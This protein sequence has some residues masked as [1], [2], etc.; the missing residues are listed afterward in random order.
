MICY[1]KNIS[2]KI[3]LVIILTL[4]VL[5]VNIFSFFNPNANNGVSNDQIRLQ[6]I[7][8]SEDTIW[9]V[10]GSPYVINET[11]VIE[12][13]AKLTIESGVQVLFNESS[14]LIIDGVL[15]ATGTSANPIIFTSNSSTPAKGDWDSIKIRG[16][17]SIISN[18]FISYAD[19]G[20]EIDGGI[21]EIINSTIFENNY[22]ILGFDIHQG[23][24]IVQNNSI[25]NSLYENLRIQD[26]SGNIVNYYIK[27]NRF[28]HGYGPAGFNCID[29]RPSDHSKVFFE[30]NEIFN[31]TRGGIRIAYC[32]LDE[33]IFQNNSIYRN[34]GTEVNDYGVIFQGIR[35]K[36]PIYV[37][38]NEIYD[39]GN[40]GMVFENVAGQPCCN[41]WIDNVTI[42]YNK[43]YNNGNDGIRFSDNKIT[44]LIF[45]HNIIS[46]NS[47]YGVSVDSQS[48]IFENFSLH[49]NEISNN[50]I[51]LYFKNWVENEY[52]V[53]Y[54]N[55]V[56]NSL[57]S[58]YCAWE[59]PSKH[60]DIKNNWWGTN[61][62][63]EI[64]DMIFDYYDDTIYAK[65]DFLPILTNPVSETYN[66]IA[67]QFKNLQINDSVILVG[68]HVN[69][70]I[71]VTDN[72][73]IDSVWIYINNYTYK[74]T[75][76]NETDTF[77][78]IFIPNVY[79]MTYNF[80]ISSNDTSGFINTI[81]GYL[82]MESL[83]QPFELFFS[84][85]GNELAL[86]WTASEFAN[87][88]SVYI[89][90]SYINQLNSSISKLIDN[91]TGL[92]FSTT[93]TNG[94]YYLVAEAYNEYGNIISNCIFV[95]INQTEYDNGG[96]GG[97]GDNNI[98]DN[99][100]F[101][102]IP[103]IIG[104]AITGIFGM[105]FIRSYLKKE[106][107]KR[108]QIPR[109]QTEELRI[110][111]EKVKEE[112][113]K[114]EIKKDEMLSPQEFLCKNCGNLI[115]ITDYLKSRKKIFCEKCGVL[116]TLPED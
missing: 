63:S 40:N 114:I 13:S 49:H 45:R 111:A 100:L 86:I 70:S 17:N 54:N 85:S 69:I 103:I 94:E 53:N 83:P 71:E 30:N 58:I 90:E 95:K 80:I 5:F 108:K 65:V 88:Y 72:V 22:G 11:I 87:G 98:T 109:P 42:Q 73:K 82:T 93:L 19:K 61:E 4:C 110:K 113:K 31:N 76:I 105:F 1:Q 56:N 26:L 16:I 68:D 27:N 43:I 33:L 96:D 41:V 92:S 115:Q 23:D 101:L 91:I 35:L 9:N 55:I 116:I 112:Y 75:N 66:A 18:A 81:N 67:P 104:I 52:N 3:K 50:T 32:D 99:N 107:I 84:I 20:V 48:Y 15:N 46:N 59:E 21:V 47:N 62:S 64:N 60:M 37:Q 29:L 77:Y 12:Q 7:Y 36:N 2:K 106:K 79:N 57:Y 51:G 97:D 6:T 89:S 39:N 25:Y 34:R 14:S 38:Y 44:S 74:M 24:L 28:F 78:Y 102:I 8:I 10:I